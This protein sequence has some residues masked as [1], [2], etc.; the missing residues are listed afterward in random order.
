MNFQSVCFENA[1]QVFGNMSLVWVGFLIGWLA[2]SVVFRPLDW[3]ALLAA[4]RDLARHSCFTA[5][6]FANE[7]GKAEIKTSGCIVS[8]QQRPVRRTA[9]ILYW[10]YFTGW[11]WTFFQPSVLTGLVNLQEF[12]FLELCVIKH[13]IKL[14][15]RVTL[16]SLCGQ[17]RLNAMI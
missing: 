6:R 12:G 11:C 4:G 8:F 2:G 9:G 15:Y 3:H 14:S 1:T 17:W 7:R 5:G 16:L 13:L 10:Q